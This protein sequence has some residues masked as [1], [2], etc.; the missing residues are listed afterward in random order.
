MEPKKAKIFTA[1]RALTTNLKNHVLKP[2]LRNPSNAM[3]TGVPASFAQDKKLYHTSH[4]SCISTEFMEYKY[5][6]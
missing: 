1:I 6:Y 2:K 3:V 5:T 4:K